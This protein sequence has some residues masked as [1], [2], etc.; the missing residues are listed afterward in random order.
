MTKR[1]SMAIVMAFL[2]AAMSLS[3]AAASGGGSGNVGVDP[4]RLPTWSG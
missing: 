3:V 2:V 1:I 4:N